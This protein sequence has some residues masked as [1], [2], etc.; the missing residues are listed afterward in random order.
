MGV[1]DLDGELGQEARP[2]GARLGTDHGECILDDGDLILVRSP[3]DTGRSEVRH[4]D[5]RSDQRRVVALVPRPAGGVE[6]HRQALR[7]AGAMDRRGQP[8][9]EIERRA[10]VGRVQR[11]ARLQRTPVVASGFVVGVGM[12]GLVGR[13]ARQ[14]RPQQSASPTG[15]ARQAWRARSDSRPSP[16]ELAKALRR[17]GVQ[18]QAAPQRQG[19]VAVRA[20]QGVD[21]GEPAWPCRQRGDQSGGLGRLQ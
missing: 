14:A 20:E 6:Q 12:L 7:I 8:D 21:E 10:R 15:T 18:V 13:L 19:F 16:D 4:R 2:H 9:V 3:E 11:A 1:A 17:A 5:R